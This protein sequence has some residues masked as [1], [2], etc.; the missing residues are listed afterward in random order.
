LSTSYLLAVGS[1]V[2]VRLASAGST[3]HDLLLE[4]AATLVDRPS[5]THDGAGRPQ[6]PGLAVSVSYSPRRVAVA[7]SYRSEERRVG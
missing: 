1:Q 2:H 5:L 3:A 4:L 6:V 7:A